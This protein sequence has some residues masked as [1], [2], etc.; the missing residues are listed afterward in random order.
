MIVHSSFDEEAYQ[1]G[2]FVSGIPAY[3]GVARCQIGFR[4]TDLNKFDARPIL[5]CLKEFSPEDLEVL[6]HSRAA[7]ATTG[8]K[9]S[10][11]AVV[12]KG[13]GKT[14]I[15]GVHAISIDEKKRELIF[16]GKR[17]PEFTEVV[18]SGTTGRLYLVGDVRSGYKSNEASPQTDETC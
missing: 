12:C 8:G 13:W 4:T 10:H 15:V 7:M 1:E 3:P 14:C 17:Y 5:L 18:I 16:Q 2:E 11:L 6:Y 9:S